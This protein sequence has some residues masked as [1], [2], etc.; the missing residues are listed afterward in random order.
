MAE[1][2]GV[3]AVIPTYNRADVLGEAIESAFAQDVPALE[4]VVVDDGSTDG[5]PQLLEEYR[6]KHGAALTVIRQEN[7]GESAARNEGI[8]RARNEL[9]ALLD[10][11][12]SWR[13]GKLAAQL[14]LHV[15]DPALEFSF[16]GYATF[17]SEHEDV[18]LEA[19][20]PDATCALEELLVGCCINTSTVVATK[21]L[22]TDV[23]LFDTSLECCQDHDLWLRIAAAGH[24]IDYVPE[25]LLDYRVHSGG[26]SSNQGLV[27][28]STEVV[29]TRLFSDGD[30]PDRVRARERS[31][32]ARWHL[33]NACRYLEAQD[34]RAA[35]RAILRAL[36]ARPAALRPGWLRLFV[37]ALWSRRPSDPRSPSSSGSVA[38]QFEGHATSDS[39]EHATGEAVGHGSSM[40]AGGTDEARSG[41]Q[42]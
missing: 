7:A 33:N 36:R 1:L 40:G 21:R 39:S 14:A 30:L 23:G 10:S 25:V 34:G 32:V 2:P 18:L 27:A 41:P 20:D 42:R 22:L 16:T 35:R 19:W 38:Q 24:R 9:V 15:S 29:I 8:L 13:P 37:E 28:A 5:T 11:D 6:A 3:S 4:V 31:H 26:T 12:N 17:G